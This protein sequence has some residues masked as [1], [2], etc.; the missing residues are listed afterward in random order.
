M[1]ACPTSEE[2]I[3]ASAAAAETARSI[4]VSVAPMQRPFTRML[5]SAS[6]IAQVSTWR[7]CTHLAQ[8]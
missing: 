5:W 3:P 6:S 4:G 8:S 2:R 7:H 1:T